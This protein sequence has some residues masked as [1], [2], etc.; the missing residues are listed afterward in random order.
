MPLE[1]LVVA[2]KKLQTSNNNHKLAWQIIK[3]TVVACNT[4][5]IFCNF[6]WIFS[7]NHYIDYG[8]GYFHFFCC[9]SFN[10]T[11]Y[12]CIVFAALSLF[13][14]TQRVKHAPFSCRL[15]HVLCICCVRCCYCG[16][17]CVLRSKHCCGM[18][19]CLIK[20]FCC[21]L[22]VVCSLLFAALLQC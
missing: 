3:V 20:N 4:V 5:S 18:C 19:C 15:L 10:F 17:F 7:C 14:S 2:Q 16:F 9:C 12:G 11:F 22:S 21:N 8:F 1:F 13:T 6:N